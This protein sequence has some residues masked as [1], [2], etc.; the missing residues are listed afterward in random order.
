MKNEKKGA[1]K[2]ALPRKQRKPRPQINK[3]AQGKRNDILNPKA[4][5]KGWTGISEY[6]TAVIHG[7]AE[8]PPKH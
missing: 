5:A 3:D 2:P 4:K 1:G 8:I 7:E 6:L